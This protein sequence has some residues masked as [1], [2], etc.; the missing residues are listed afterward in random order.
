MFKSLAKVGL[1]SFLVTSHLNAISEYFSCVSCHG[2]KGERR[3]LGKSKV[4]QDM[5]P[6]EIINALNGY[7]S[8]TYGGSMKEV[9]KSQVMKLSKSD[10]E[11]IAI[12]ISDKAEE[13]NLLL[14]KYQD[15][16]TNKSTEEIS[17]LLLKNTGV[18][19]SND[20]RIWQLIRK[21]TSRADAIIKL[22]AEKDLFPAS[23]EDIEKNYTEILGAYSPYRKAGGEGI[24]IINVS[25]GPNFQIALDE[26][27][28]H[29]YG[30]DPSTARWGSNG[31]ACKKL[32]ESEKSK[33]LQS[34]KEYEQK[35]AEE[36][37][38]WTSKSAL[39]YLQLVI[40][41]KNNK[42]LSL[43]YKYMGEYYD[44]IDETYQQ[45]WFA[46]NGKITTSFVSFPRLRSQ[47]Y[48]C[49]TNPFSSALKLDAQRMSNF[50]KV[51][52][53]GRVKNTVEPVVTVNGFKQFI[54]DL[55]TQKIFN[56][57]TNIR[58]ENQKYR[59][60]I[61]GDFIDKNGKTHTVTY[62]I[63]PDGYYISI[64]SPDLMVGTAMLVG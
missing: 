8:G 26:S 16:Y 59:Y 64:D 49:T 37:K 63:E 58:E 28:K 45:F 14:K 40:K 27:G 20:P 29:S 22:C 3:A 48:E 10:I 12:H 42:E 60:K 24:S 7:K 47:R 13:K 23:F 19:V 51:S 17:N 43:A 62:H 4:I 21:G 50:G 9:M 52:S 25:D 15:L 34:K 54:N 6:D 30:K 38:T 57:L 35:T 32:S 53:Y 1:V 5:S 39:Q 41:A 46:N 33:I 55:K 36:K 44:K 61:H 56:I 31:L 2:E 18:Y 11:K